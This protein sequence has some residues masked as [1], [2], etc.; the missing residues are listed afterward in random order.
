MNLANQYSDRFSYKIQRDCQF[1][2]GFEYSLYDII[3]KRFFPL[4]Y[5]V[6]LQ[7]QNNILFVIPYYRFGFLLRSQI[8]FLAI[9]SNVSSVFWICCTTFR[10]Y[11]P[12]GGFY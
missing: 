10:G 9:L 1:S 2:A 8:Y 4:Y 12:G 5:S 6:V 7:F 11:A 3:M